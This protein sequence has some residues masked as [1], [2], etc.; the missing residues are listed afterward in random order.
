MIMLIEYDV[1]TV[2][3][4]PVLDGVNDAAVNGDKIRCVVNV[5]LSL[6]IR[7]DNR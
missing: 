5:G 4:P 1:S 2:S 3:E 7:F 6:L